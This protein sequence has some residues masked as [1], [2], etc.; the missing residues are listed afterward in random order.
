MT[1]RALVTG[2][3]GFVGGHLRARLSAAGFDVVPGVGIDNTA[4]PN[5]IRFDLCDTSSVDNLVR[6]AAPVDCVVHLAAI[7]FVPDAARNPDRVMD[8]NLSG[9][10]R[11]LDAV[12]RHAPDARVLFV[13]SSEAY[14]PPQSLPVA[15]SHPL[16]P[17]NP[18]AISK[19]AADLYCAYLHRAA[20]LDIV[21]ARPFNHS[22]PGQPDSFVLSSFARQIA[23]VERGSRPPIMRTG[24]LNVARDFSHV[25]DVVDAYL[26]LI[27]SGRSGE[28]YNICS[29]TALPLRS[30]LDR[31]L[32]MTDKKIEV[33]TD[34][35]R[36][37]NTDIPEIRGTHD[38]L[39]ADT[40]WSPRRTLDDLLADL[41]AHWRAH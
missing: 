27:E 2:A 16:A 15:E 14:G 30:I 11:L 38:K 12:Q 7:T 41:L 1:R 32:A 3:E 17:A 24:N 10:I 4:I 8:V 20:G 36:L 21:R 5:A 39:T 37:R 18:Y 13:G 28:A 19:A 23:G 6:R 26:G 29:G 25:A 35:D 34:P 40:G 33:E 22:G 31:F 9:T